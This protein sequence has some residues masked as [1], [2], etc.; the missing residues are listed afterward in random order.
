MA[1]RGSFNYDEL[2]YDNYQESL[3]YEA[4]D[5]HMPSFEDVLN[6]GFSVAKQISVQL[7]CLLCVNFIYRLIRQSSECKVGW[8][9]CITFDI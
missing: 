2:D 4:D 3:D 1:Y 6:C 8:F 9:D 5:D 7:F